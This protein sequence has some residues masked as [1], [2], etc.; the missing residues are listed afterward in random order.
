MIYKTLFLFVIASGYANASTAS[1]TG[2]WSVNCYGFGGY[3]NIEK[4]GA[5][6]INVND[7]NLYIDAKMKVTEP[8]LAELYFVGVHESRNEVIDFD[9]IE[10]S[11]PIARLRLINNRINLNWLG[12]FDRARKKYIWDK[13]ADFV[14]ATDGK[15]IIMSRCIA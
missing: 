2:Y 4:D 14:V 10:I 11:R 1:Y 3:I 6:T 7:N 12:F 9:A 15:D 13:Q 8:G 5:T